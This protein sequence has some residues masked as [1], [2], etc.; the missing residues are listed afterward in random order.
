TLERTA[1]QEAN[2][3]QV[4]DDVANLGDGGRL[5]GVSVNQLE[6]SA[7]RG[8]DPSDA[9][10]WRRR[11]S[12]EGP[13]GIGR[14]TQGIGWVAEVV[15]GATIDFFRLRGGPRDT[16][17]VSI[18]QIGG[19]TSEGMSQDAMLRPEERQIVNCDGRE[20]VRCIQR[21]QCMFGGCWIQRDWGGG[22]PYD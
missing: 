13:A 18:G 19:P 10:E 7:R 11:I 6:D 14:R 21:G 17:L 22:K 8:G 5:I 12:H 16:G 4:V 1:P 20:S 15:P 3:V 9:G 2:R